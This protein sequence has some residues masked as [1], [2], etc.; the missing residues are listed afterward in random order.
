MKLRHRIAALGSIVADLNVD[1]ISALQWSPPSRI[2]SWKIGHTP[3]YDR[4]LE[5]FAVL[6]VLA[7]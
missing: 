6:V 7:L 2:E 4:G 3:D 5:S 1:E